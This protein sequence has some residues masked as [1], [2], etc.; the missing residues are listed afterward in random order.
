LFK[1]WQVFVVALMCASYPSLIHGKTYLQTTSL[2]VS[3]DS[4]LDALSVGTPGSVNDQAQSSTL[5]VN[6]TDFSGLGSIDSASSSGDIALNLDNSDAAAMTSS[7]ALI[8]KALP[9]PNPM[10]FKEGMGEIF[11]R[12]SD[13]M[14]IEIRVYDMTGSQIY[15]KAFVAGTPGGQS[16]QNSVAFTPDTVGH[17]LP[18]GVYPFVVIYKEA[19]LSKGMIAIRV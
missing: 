6:S 19:V 12:L 9:Y 14:D 11:Y 1:K 18:V 2:Q 16:G 5:A 8:G 7:P 10:K 17:D 13:D 4:G 15:K 3:Q